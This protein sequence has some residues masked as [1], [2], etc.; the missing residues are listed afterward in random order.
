MYLVWE[1]VQC[2]G[3]KERK[4]KY[5]MVSCRKIY[6]SI[7]SLYYK[8][9]KLGIF[10]T[11]AKLGKSSRSQSTWVPHIYK[12][13]VSHS[14]SFSLTSPWLSLAHTHGIRT[15]TIHHQRGGTTPE[16]LQH[17]R[18][19]MSYPHAK[20]TQLFVSF[21]FIHSRIYLFIPYTLLRGYLQ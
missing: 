15:S 1:K 16:N 7:S 17:Y 3:E 20:S 8:I 4:Q 6:L 9:T 18:N 19:A 10:T 14:S 12:Q 13:R 2:R 21:L 11:F 5:D